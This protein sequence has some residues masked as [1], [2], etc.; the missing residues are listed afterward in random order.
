MSQNGFYVHDNVDSTVR[1]LVKVH[2]THASSD[3]NLLLGHSPTSSHLTLP[4][5]AGGTPIDSKFYMKKV[6]P[7]IKALLQKSHNSLVPIKALGRI[8]PCLW[9]Q[10]DLCITGLACTSPLDLSDSFPQISAESLKCYVVSYASWTQ[11]TWVSSPLTRT[12]WNNCARQSI[13][14][15]HIL[16]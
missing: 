10:N 9:L 11:S 4:L 2:W 5:E 8:E 3:I 6:E 12:V 13:V 15:L 16:F 7:K 14:K 1:K